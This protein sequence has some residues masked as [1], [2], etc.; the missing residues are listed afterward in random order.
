MS[1]DYSKTDSRAYVEF[2]AKGCKRIKQSSQKEKYEN[3]NIYLVNVDQVPDEFDEE[4]STIEERQHEA[5]LLVREHD[6][7]LTDVQDR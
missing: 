2:H 3:C 4:D 1:T 5:F 7:E 6:G